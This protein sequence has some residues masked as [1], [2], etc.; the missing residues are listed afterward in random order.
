LTIDDILKRSDITSPIPK[1]FKDDLGF[2]GLG[3]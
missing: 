3:G 1:G 2:Y